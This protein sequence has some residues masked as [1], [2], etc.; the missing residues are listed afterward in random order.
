M[1][2]RSR[3]STVILLAVCPLLLQAQDRSG[4]VKA[5]CLACHSSGAAA[6]AKK[7]IEAA[8][9]A[10]S[11]HAA[12]SCTDCHD[13][14]VERAKGEPPHPKDIPDVNCTA[15][16]HREPKANGP[17]LSPLYYS[18]S[19]HGQSYLQRGAKDVAHC[20]DCHGQHNIL[21]I[22]D[23]QSLA[24]RRNI[25]L[26][27]SRCHDDMAVV[28]KYHIHYERPYQEYNKSVH[29][30]ALVD[31]GLTS[32]AAVCTDCH[33]VHNI[34]GVG[35]PNLMARRPQTCGRCHAG[36]FDEYKSSIHG[37]KAL[38]GNLDVPGCSDCHGEHTIA[39]PKDAQ[40]S[41]SPGHIPDTCSACHA[42]PEIIK[43]YGI[44]ENRISTFIN[45]LHG[46]AIGFGDKA[47]ANCTSCHGVHDIRP[48]ADPQSKVNPANLAQ[49]CGRKNCHP[50][51]PASIA[52]AKIHRSAD[53]KSGGAV[54]IVRNVLLG[55]VVATMAATLLWFLSD[56]LR[57]TRRS[58]R[59]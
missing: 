3:F 37:Q 47:A 50:G 12:L 49:T 9:L 59:P 36:I 34:S 14:K 42:R 19:I 56:L 44:P 33:G 35:T 45:S 5:A 53:D 32:F 29:G 28:V 6:S 46:I 2:M 16:C 15:R 27:C 7:T 26:T 22:A 52:K 20:W 43:K 13:V 57:K 38:A 41:T 17:G 55:L 24:N 11:V 25:P 54:F 48:A 4:Q 30:R 51:M 23:P 8:P 18:D 1:A 10:S 58:R 21:P 40:A 31:K 39:S